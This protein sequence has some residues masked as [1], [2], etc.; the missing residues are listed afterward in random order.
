[1]TASAENGG[2]HI[3]I[4]SNILAGLS[5]SV[6]A[7]ASCLNAAIDAT[8]LYQ[9]MAIPKHTSYIHT[10]TCPPPKK[11]RF[12]CGARMDQLTNMILWVSGYDD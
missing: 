1:M 3:F 2:Y 10:G 11:K 5:Q 6:G 4:I 9:Y 8:F 12:C 7:E